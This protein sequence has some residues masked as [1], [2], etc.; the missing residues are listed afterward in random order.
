MKPRIR[1][2]VL[3][4]ATVLALPA[5]ASANP[6]DSVTPLSMCALP[7]SNPVAAVATDTTV[8][9]A[10]P[11]SQGGWHSAPV[12]ITLAGTAVQ[13]FEW[14][15][16]CDPL[17]QT[18]PSATISTTGEHTF[19]HRVIEAPSGDQTPWIEDT[20][21][22]DVTD[23]VDTTVVPATW[24]DDVATITFN[25][26]DTAGTPDQSG[27]ATMVY[28]LDGDP[29]VPVN[30]GDTLNITENGTFT[31]RTWIVDN[32][33]NQSAPRNS[34]VRVDSADPVDTTTVPAG[35]QTTPSVDVT[36]EGTDS[37][38]EGITLVEWQLDGVPHSAAGP[39]PVTVTVSGEGDHVLSTRLTDGRG[40]DSG[41]KTQH[42]RIDT[43]QPTDATTATS[44]W[45]SQN[46]LD[47]TVQGTDAT[48]GVARVVYKLDGGPE[49][50]TNGDTATATVTGTGEHTLETQVYDVAGNASAFK[51]HTIRLDPTNP[52][53]STPTGSDAWRTT[54]YSVRVN[55][56]D[57]LS[58]VNRVEWR[59]NNGA[60][61]SG[62]PGVLTALVTGDGSHTLST[63]VVDNAGNASVWRDE[64][65]RIDTVKPADTTTVPA[66]VGRGRK[67]PITA[68]DALSG[69]SGAVEWQVDGG[70]IKTSSPAILGTS[71][72]H[73]LKTRV[74]DNAG[75][76]SD[77]KTANVT[78]TTVNEDTTDPVDTTSI[79]TGWRPGPYEVVVTA[80]DDVE[81][82]EVQYRFNGDIVSGPSGLRFTVSTDGVHE[83][84]TRA[85]DTAGNVSTWRPHTLQIDQTRPVDTSALTSGWTKTRAVELTGTDETSGVASVAYQVNGGAVTTVNADHASF[86][87]PSDGTFVIRHRVTDNAE[88]QSEWKTDTVKVDTAVPVNTSPVA[89]S[90][91][92]ATALSVALTG[93]DVGSGVDRY[94][95]RVGGGEIK[96]GNAAVVTTDGAQILQTRVVDKAGNE[97]TWRN[98]TIKVDLTKP[99]NTTP[100]V[101]SPWR[102]SN[103]ATTVSGTDA[104]SGVARVEWKL[105]TGS[106]STSPAVAIAVEGNYKLWTRVIDVA[107]NDSGWRADSVGIDKSAPSLA[108]DCGAAV[109]RN[110]PA[111]CKVA[112]DG[113][114]SGLSVLTGARGGEGATAVAG[115]AY[116]VEA[117]GTSTVT[118]KAIDGAGNEVTAQGTVKVDRTA[119][120]AT[121]ACTP[122][123]KSLNHIC[124]AT[125]TDL[126]SGLA[127]VT[128]SV[129]G[130]APTPIA[131][132]AS[133]T[134]AKG[135]V[136]V[137]A[138][139][140]AGN[141]GASAPVSLAERHEDEHEEGVTP[142]S[143]SEAV[144]LKGS[145]AKGS[146]SKRLVGQLALS[147]TPT[148]T[149]VDL[150]PL[151]LGSG[152]FQLVLK[153]T[154]GKKTKTF[155][156]TQ[157][158][159]KGYSKRVTV[160]AAAGADAKVALTVKRKSGKRWVTHATASA[161]L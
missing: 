107:G 123:P 21:K 124:T 125:G 109:W 28:E 7:P 110:A 78:V 121:V 22:V 126:L 24:H 108:A 101:A 11:T 70:A 159:V 117:E 68:T 140:G 33:G 36:V 115:G 145:S 157:K 34:I 66:S 86:T 4:L 150:R 85:I 60:A 14:T 88:R 102:S 84:E 57:E 116:T 141:V 89:P 83:I 45:L 114:I 53:N 42:V 113:G 16:D 99:V 73:V 38:G 80:D 151:A 131:P 160:K 120:T 46:S 44:A 1:I 8:V 50:S 30:P 142:R 63:R 137:R 64:T 65:I 132:G 136:V 119:P 61:T 90:T 55:G 19:T 156:K 25:G 93:T 91:W 161:H 3:M 39:G 122:D 27:V 103:F 92:Q 71:G 96:S 26:H 97:S 128:W 47:V 158:T 95:W 82:A 106:V 87:L 15:I 29:G 134:V 118:F 18:G 54:P 72:A 155:T 133:F 98:D 74:Q 153:V 49:V 77:W 81:L 9:P 37:G 31:L 104:A 12:N 127:G 129:N 62:A 135:K 10:G 58:G 5:T 67:I 130:G 23:P 75:N 17:L 138:T 20:V 35:W 111:V 48:S 112:A 76:W 79:A 56:S 59:V 41:W 147:S 43:V 2:L 152:T 94:E 13:G 154:V 143:T 105:D 51:T 149:T 146:A 6:W 40:H 69:P 52:S 100:V 139:D 148:A 144:L 32:A